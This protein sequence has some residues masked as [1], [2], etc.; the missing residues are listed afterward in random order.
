M[1]YRHIVSPVPVQVLRALLRST[2]RVAWRSARLPW[3]SF[4]QGFS[5]VI[6]D[7][8]VGPLPRSGDRHEQVEGP[9]LA[10]RHGDR[11]R[12]LLPAQQSPPQPGRPRDGKDE[13][14]VQLSGTAG[15]AGGCAERG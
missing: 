8:T 5:P 4:L 11:S 9:R 7:L 15:S 1:S 14:Q 2:L 3:S 10:A 6:G 12:Q 13:R